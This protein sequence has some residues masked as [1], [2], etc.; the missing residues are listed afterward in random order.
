MRII[1]IHS[2]TKREIHGSFDICGSK[3]DLRVLAK[4]ILKKTKNFTYGWISI[5]DKPSICA[6]T[7][8]KGWDD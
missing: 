5:V 4:E 1:I 7:P 8:P 3:D 6:N 2:K